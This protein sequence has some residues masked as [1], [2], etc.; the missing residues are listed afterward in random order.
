MRLQPPLMSMGFAMALVFLATPPS[1]ATVLP[2]LAPSYYL[3]EGSATVPYNQP[4]GYSS[5]AV[6]S[7]N[8]PE[9]YISPATVPYQ[10]ES[11]LNPAIA[12]YNEPVSNEYDYSSNSGIYAPSPLYVAPITPSIYEAT[13]LYHPAPIT[14]VIYT[15]PVSLLYSG[16]QDIPFGGGTPPVLNVITPSAP[17]NDLF[18]A[19]TKTPDISTAFDN[20]PVQFGP[21]FVVPEPRLGALALLAALA[22]GIVVARRRK[23]EAESPLQS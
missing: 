15:S 2:G 19:D 6:V 18:T 11:Y 1:P 22:L 7:Y 5:P 10:P 9:S 12:P 13:P 23:K 8:Q 17:S 3:P 4:G 20:S 14:P 16:P 21:A